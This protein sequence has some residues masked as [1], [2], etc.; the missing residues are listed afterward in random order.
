MPEKHW[1]KINGWKFVAAFISMHN[2]LDLIYEVPYITIAEENN[3][4]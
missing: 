2:K 4:V 3:L 1:G